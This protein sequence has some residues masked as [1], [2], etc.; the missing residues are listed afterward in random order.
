MI[1]DTEI[2][3]QYLGATRI[4]VTKRN[5]EKGE[6]VKRYYML[7]CLSVL[8][9]DSKARRNAL[10]FNETLN[11]SFPN[12][13]TQGSWLFMTVRNFNRAVF[14]IVQSYFIH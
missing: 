11:P 13:K 8:G 2:D 6:R 14:G 12:F 10:V 1:C 4:T 5:N 9:R 3:K 7:V